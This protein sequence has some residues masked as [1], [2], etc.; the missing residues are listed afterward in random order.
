MARKSRS[1]A[2]EQTTTAVAP[3]PT[4][5]ASDNG[6]KFAGGF[7]P[8]KVLIPDYWTLRGR[9]TQLFETNLYARGLIRRL[10]TN[11]INTGLHLE[12][13][14]EETVL[15]YPR[16]GLAEWSE[17]VE[18]RFALWGAEPWLCDWIEQATFGE[19]QEAAFLEALIAGDCLVVLR[20]DPLTKLPRVQ[21]V[22]GDCVQSP[23]VLPRGGNKI[24]HGVELDAQGR[25]VAFWIRQS[26]GSARRLPAYGE[27]S[28]RRLAW[29]VYGS[30]KRLDQVR[31]KPI[32]ALALQAMLEIDRYR[33]STQRKATINSMLAMFVEKAQAGPGT[34]PMAA[35]AVR[36]GSIANTEDAGAPRRFNVAEHIPGIVLDE[37]AAG[38]VPRAFP[39][40]GTDLA[41]PEFERAIIAGVAWGYEVPPEILVL[42]FGSNYAASQ[43]AINEFKIFL[44]RVRTRWGERFCQP[45][46]VEWL[47][48]SV[49][50]QKIAAKDLID[51]WRDWKRYDLFCAWTSADWSGNIKPAV[52]LS[53]LVK[54]YGEMV[55]RGF[56]TRARATRELNGT[57]YSRNVQT[58][59]IENAALADA[60]KP[61]AELLAPAAS[62]ELPT[63][64]DEVDDEGNLVDQPEDDELPNE[65]AA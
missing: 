54:A 19:I 28:G 8:T 10:V 62:G 42:S 63:L 48:A 13:Q 26:D 30:D 51:S 65:R 49:L 11:I 15:G 50:A 6:S 41:F 2:H 61:L 60:N 14:P 22:R 16:D 33:D 29:L 31:G 53:K 43:A 27:K 1:K 20:Q 45:I 55:D 59:A 17:E 40:N 52:D 64:D 7:G 4:R 57:K 44:N 5:V 36:V 39:S 35:G 34:R 18:T 38:E 56:M 47:L 21:L 37:L 58:L 32:L 12:A 3:A 24:E 9:S 25:H 46:Y 23:G